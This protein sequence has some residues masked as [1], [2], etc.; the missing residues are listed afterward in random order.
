MTKVYFAKEITSDSLIKIYEK[1]GITLKGN[2]AVKLHSGEAGNQNYLKPEFLKGIINK[3]NG[4][5]VECN[6][7]YNGARNTT[8][9]HE[10]LMEEH[11]WSKYYNVDIMDSNGPDKVL[12]IPNGNVIKKNY[13]GKNIE[14]YDS[15]LVLSHFKGHPMGGFGGALKQLSIGVASS[16]G[17]A[18]IHTAGKTTDVNKLWENLPSQDNFIEA[19][20]DAASS[21]HNYFK[22]NIAYINIMKNMSVDC[23][24]CAEA[25][26][27]CM[28]DIGIL[29]SLDPVAIDKACLDLVYNSTDPGKNHLIERIE[30]RHGNHIIDASCKLNFGSCEYELINID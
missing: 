28:K 25:E 24:C 18:Y 15:M 13:V 29:A 6:T 22:G 12:E 3:V 1:L 9:K 7:A 4:T 30:T 8:S 2:V 20:A 17:K 26:D 19:M 23:D 11:G 14:K 27:P 21:V 5:V 10:K 16:A